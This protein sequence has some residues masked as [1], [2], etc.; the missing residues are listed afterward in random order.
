VEADGGGGNEACWG[1][2]FEL[3][4]GGGGG[5]GGGVPPLYGSQFV[6]F[7]GTLG[8]TVSLMSLPCN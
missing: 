8:C 1:R 6:F 5:G 7:N 4:R 3:T 2:L